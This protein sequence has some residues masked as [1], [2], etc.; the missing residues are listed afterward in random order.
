MRTESGRSAAV[1]LTERGYAAFAAGDVDVLL[2]LFAE[3]IEWHAGGAHPMAG[4]HRGTDEV[5]GFLATV[6]EQV[7]GYYQQ[8]VRR[9]IVGQDAED[10]VVVLVHCEAGR[11]GVVVEADEVHL[12]FYRDGRLARFVGYATDFSGMDALLG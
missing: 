7:E 10:P 12:H 1:E 2:A 11:D 6:L 5:L 4:V 8:D 9:I 3:D